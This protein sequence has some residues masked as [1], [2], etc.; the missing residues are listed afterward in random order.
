[1]ATGSLYTYVKGGGGLIGVKHNCRLTF[2][3]EEHG[4]EK[5][6][7]VSGAVVETWNAFCA[8]AISIEVLDPVD[9]EYSKTVQYLQVGRL[10]LWRTQQRIQQ[11]LDRKPA[12]EM[13]LKYPGGMLPSNDGG[14][15]PSTAGPFL[16]LDGENGIY[17]GSEWAIFETAL[18]EIANASGQMD[19]YKEA[20]D[21]KGVHGLNGLEAYIDEKAK[22]KK[23]KAGV[24]AAAQIQKADEREK[25]VIVPTRVLR[26]PWE[27]ANQA[28]QSS[29]P[30]VQV[31]AP[32][33]VQAP[34]AV[35]AQA[36]PTQ[37]VTPI[38]PTTPP[39]TTQ[40]VAAAPAQP[41][42]PGQP[43]FDALAIEWVLKAGQASGG[44]IKDKAALVNFVFNETGKPGVLQDIGGVKAGS[45]RVGIMQRLNK[46]EWVQAAADAG[47]FL[48]APDGSIMVLAQ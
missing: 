30:G 37:T 6:D 23:Q 1:M 26:W 17:E 42:Q 19:A 14:E 39:P 38:V 28:S 48:V 18:R 33:A 29:S 43:D 27:P 35:A 22:P 4:F 20:L 40:P 45:V 25:T 24:P 36:A 2:N 10:P 34:V 31:P 3:L 41:S 5:K 7:K 13:Q 11:G 15:T 44:T 32:Q 16:H 12:D 21:K 8:A 9:P 47:H 46:P